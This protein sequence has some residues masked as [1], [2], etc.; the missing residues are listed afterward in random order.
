MLGFVQKRILSFPV[1]MKYYYVPDNG[2]NLY[3]GL[4]N[5]GWMFFL[6]A[7][8][9]PNLIAWKKQFSIPGSSIANYNGDIIAPEEMEMIITVR[10]GVSRLFSD[11]ELQI[12]SLSL[13]PHNLIRRDIGRVVPNSRCIGNEDCWD[14]CLT[15]W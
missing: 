11:H 13:G 4:D 3:I 6:C 1:I 9:F 10:N 2:P 7:D 5:P 14:L 8:V 12:S 15:K